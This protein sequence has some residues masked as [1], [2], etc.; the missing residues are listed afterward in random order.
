[1]NKNSLGRLY[2]DMGKWFYYYTIA[3]IIIGILQLGFQIAIAI[4][5]RDMTNA[6]EG[7]NLQLLISAVVKASLYTLFL[8]FIHPIF[9]Y[10]SEKAAVNVIAN[11]RL[12]LFSRM[13]ELSIGYLKSSHSG[14]LI[15]R[16]TND[17]SEVEAFTR[18]NML[19]FIE[20]IIRS[21]GAA[22]FMLVLDW[23]LALL[24]ISFTVLVLKINTIYAHKLNEISNN[25]QIKLSNLTQQLSDIIGGIQVIKGFNLNKLFVDKFNGLN[26]D[27]CQESI[28]R[29]NKNAILSVINYFTFMG[30]FL[31]L[32]FAGSYLTVKGIITVGV[33]IGCIQLHGNVGA[34]FHNL[35]TFNTKLQT[36]VVSLNRIYEIDDKEME[37]AKYERLIPIKGTTEGMVTFK[38]VS[39]Q[40]SQEDMVLKNLNFNI[41]KGEVVA[42]VGESGGGKSTIFKLLLGF[43]SPTVGNIAVDGVGMES[44]ALMDIRSKISYVPQDAYLFAGTI[45]EN[46]LY[47]CPEATF[48]E[49]VEAAKTANAHDFILSL[50]NGYETVVG[51]RG[52]QLSGGQ[53]QRIAIARALLKNAPI[54]LLDEATSALDTESEYLVQKALNRLMEGRTTL[55]IA[56]RLST[57]KRADKLMVIQDGTIVEEGNHQKLIENSTS[58]YSS[59]YNKQLESSLRVDEI[60]A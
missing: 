40:Y 48:D 14:D 60:T 32:I 50:E 11:M 31:M 20:V 56:H 34:L 44:Q 29:E 43:Y 54:L 36:F 41:S 19:A 4:M 33:I 17:M 23:R 49:I 18:K 25:V 45:K 9:K 3:A 21:V 8:F 22:A 12:N 37:P 51:E 24:S 38:D 10:I 13:Q 2:K 53:R 6:I 46:I 27:L 16:M 26:E 1:M 42:F 28:N 7:G 59:L 35:A 58:I 5:L 30:G 55:I 39:F 52:A 15:S 47:G 57:I